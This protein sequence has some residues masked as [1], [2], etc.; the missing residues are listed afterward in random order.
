MKTERI[1]LRHVSL[2]VVAAAVALSISVV[3]DVCYDRFMYKRDN[4][5]PR[6]AF[7]VTLLVFGLA[8]I[9]PFILFSTVLWSRRPTATT[10]WS[11]ISSATAGMII[12]LAISHGDSAM[13]EIIRQ[14]FRSQFDCFLPYLLLNFLILPVGLA[15]IVARCTP[16]F[17][18]PGFD[19]ILRRKP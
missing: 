14:L 12:A 9:P 11:L 1:V 19:V 7:A 17:S 16:R 13:E 18:A 3:I 10:S 4:Y 6:E 15:L 2:A 5:S 8:C